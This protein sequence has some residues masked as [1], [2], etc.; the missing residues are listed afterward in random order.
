M[1]GPITLEILDLLNLGYLLMVLGAL[2]VLIPGR[3]EIKEII[4]ESI[5]ED[6]DTDTTEA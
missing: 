3:D 4:K 6:R 5:R 2:L 1:G